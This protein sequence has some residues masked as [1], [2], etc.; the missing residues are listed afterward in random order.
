MNEFSPNFAYSNPTPEPKPKTEEKPQKK[1]LPKKEPRN[2]ETRFEM[3]AGVILVL[4]TAILVFSGIAGDYY[5]K[6][7]IIASSEKSTAYDWYNSKTIKQNLIE[8]QKADLEAL[9]GSGVL[10]EQVS[11]EFKQYLEKLENVSIR[12]KKLKDTPDVNLGKAYPENIYL[13]LEIAKISGA[14]EALINS[15]LLQTGTQER[16]RDHIVELQNEIDRYDKEKTEILQGSENL[17][18]IKWAQEID[19]KLGKVVGTKDWENKIEILN[20]AG[21]KINLARLFLE[22][23]LILGAISLVMRKPQNK[24][25][26][27]T[28]SILVGIVGTGFMIWG[29]TIVWPF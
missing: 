15:D 26:F 28:L 21:G 8:G 2:H 24:W 16:L 3:I 10:K 22:I 23:M 6:S 12:I 9:I 4:F 19:G 13:D 17:D 20:E 27:L 1:E 5:S 11:L 14:L 29:L 7:I 18:P 25:V